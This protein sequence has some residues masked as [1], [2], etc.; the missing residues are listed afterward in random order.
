MGDMLVGTMSLVAPALPHDDVPQ[1][2]EVSPLSL[3][4]DD[5]DLLDY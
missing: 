3:S 1:L 2:V 4:I 5:E